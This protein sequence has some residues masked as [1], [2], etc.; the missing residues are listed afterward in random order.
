MMQALSDDTVSGA[1]P[2]AAK[3]GRLVSR[4]GRN[5]PPALATDGHLGV[6]EYEVE[7]VAGPEGGGR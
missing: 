1:A 4:M 2:D 3:V 5:Q 6:Q 7:R